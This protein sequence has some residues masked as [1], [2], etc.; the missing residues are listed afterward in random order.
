LGGHPMIKRTRA[1]LLKQVRFKRGEILLP[2]EVDFHLH[3]A[4][5]IPVVCEAVCVPK[6]AGFLQALKP[7]R[8]RV[9]L[10]LTSLHTISFHVGPYPWRSRQM[11]RHSAC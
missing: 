5:P 8:D 6:L 9:P 7:R 1:K 10:L 4:S 11:P 2:F 3:F